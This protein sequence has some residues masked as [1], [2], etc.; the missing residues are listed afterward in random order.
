MNK[1]FFNIIILSIASLIVT[2][3]VYAQKGAIT[4]GIQLKP[5]IPVSIFNIGSNNLESANMEVGIS[6]RIGFS[7]GGV[8]RV[9]ITERLSIETGLHYIG[10]NFLIEA[11]AKNVLSQDRGQ[12]RYVNY[13]LP[14]QGMVFVRIGERLYMNTALGLSFNFWPSGIE[15]LGENRR[16]KHTTLRHNRT[17]YSFIGN[18]GLEYRTDKMGY[19]Y[20]GISLHNP[21][22]R[23]SRITYIAYEDARFGIDDEFD[24]QL[25]GDFLSI[26]FRFLFK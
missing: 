14:V 24:T 15:S 5:I 11:N 20:A 22:T 4:A 26:D 8:V 6:P 7:Y 13:E 9:G 19:F 16:I 12:F 17:T 25:R 3:G 1:R 10:R 21:L 18:L 2:S 23:I